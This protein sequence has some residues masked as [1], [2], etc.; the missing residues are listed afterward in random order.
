MVLYGNPNIIDP[1]FD[2]PLSNQQFIVYLK[3]K[4]AE[5]ANGAQN[6][7][8]YTQATIHSYQK[9]ITTVDSITKTTAIKTV[10]V[11]ENTYNTIT[12]FTQTQ[13]FSNGSTVKYTLSKNA[14]SIYDYENQVNESK[15][16]IKLINSTY[17]TQMETQYQK[18]VSA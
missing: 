16:N 15:R 18:L 6:A 9:V 17:T 7:V 10:E 8:S 4:Y 2:W 5:A 12:P 1:Q 11:D 3:D 13:S 14:L